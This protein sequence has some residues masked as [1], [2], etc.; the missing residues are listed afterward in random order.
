M[1]KVTLTLNYK[2]DINGYITGEAKRNLEAQRPGEGGTLGVGYYAVGVA[3]PS[4]NATYVKWSGKLSW[5]PDYDY[6]GVQEVSK[7]TG[8]TGVYWYHKVAK[9][10]DEN[11]EFKEGTGNWIPISSETSYEYTIEW[12]DGNLEDNGKLISI[13]TFTVK[14]VNE[15]NEV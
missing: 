9:E 7:F 10:V 14:V 13:D 11:G 15:S 5:V 2:L 1:Y 8:N 3:R 6:S 12:Y 4:E